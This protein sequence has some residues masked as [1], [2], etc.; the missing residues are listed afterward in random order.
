MAMPLHYQLQELCR[1]TSQ[2]LLGFVLANLNGVI[3]IPI[4][5]I[6]SNQLVYLT[7]HSTI[8]EVFWAIGMLSTSYDVSPY[9]IVCF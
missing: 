1:F 3:P 7:T 8:H 2:N 5:N 9:H 4:F 6:D